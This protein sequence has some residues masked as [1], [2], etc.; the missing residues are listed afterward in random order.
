M[1]TVEPTSQLNIQL[2]ANGSP[3]SQT[4]KNLC[5][6]ISISLTFGKHFHCKN[7]Y[8]RIFL[9]FEKS[10]PFSQVTTLHCCEVILQ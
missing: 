4:N 7:L 3:Q 8:P 5:Y 10:L 6:G 1:C 2:L 9:P